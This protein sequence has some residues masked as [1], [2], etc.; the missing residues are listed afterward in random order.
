M[1]TKW[2][3]R[4][5]HLDIDTGEIIKEIELKN[6][7]LIKTDKYASVQNGHG[8]IEYTKQYKRIYAGNLFD[9]PDLYTTTD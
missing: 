9:D 5:I 8:T 7:T 3:T 4:I 6:F 1:E 2:K